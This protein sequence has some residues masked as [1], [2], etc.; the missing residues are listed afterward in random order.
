MDDGKL[1]VC[2]LNA[3]NLSEFFGLAM[4]ILLGKQKED[5]KVSCFEVHDKVAI[6][7]KRKMPVQ[8]DGDFIGHLPI[9][10]KVRPKALHI[11]TPTGTTTDV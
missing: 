9:L 2:L 4:S 7:A 11:V 1:N 10:V 3:S 8:A 5:P 6:R